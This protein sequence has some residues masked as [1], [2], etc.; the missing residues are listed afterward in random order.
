DFE[1]SGSGNGG[2][3]AGKRGDGGEGGDGVGGMRGGE[4]RMCIPA[5]LLHPVKDV[6][7][8]VEAPPGEEGEG[9]VE[10]DPSA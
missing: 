4:G 7:L 9:E 1:K 6:E 3:A 2:D 10:S 5:M 8:P